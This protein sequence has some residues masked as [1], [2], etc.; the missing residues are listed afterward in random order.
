MSQPIIGTTSY[1]RRLPSGTSKTGRRQYRS[2][3]Q[4]RKG[5]RACDIIL[6]EGP[7]TPQSAA[8]CSNCAKTRKPCTLVWLNSSH[9]AVAK[10]KERRGSSQYQQQM[11]EQHM[12][13]ET[14]WEDALTNLDDKLYPEPGD[15][16]NASFE[17]P[18]SCPFDQ[19]FLG[20]PGQKFCSTDSTSAESLLDT[21]FIYGY[22][23]GS[24]E[25]GF[26]NRGNICSPLAKTDSGYD[27]SI[28]SPNL[29]TPAN[30][31]NPPVHKKFTSPRE[32]SPKRRRS[33]SSSSPKPDTDRTNG[34][35]N[36]LL[37]QTSSHH[38][39]L[40]SPSPI[41]LEHRIALSYSKA[42]ISSGLVRIY[43]DSRSPL[44]FLRLSTYIGRIS[45]V[46][47]DHHR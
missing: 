20:I 25:T 42:S 40:R 23:T 34:R 9:Q 41:S 11:A 15:T 37:C 8:P 4:C 39:S 43:H 16:T 1:R 24:I 22:E 2:C 38:R 14:S 36:L 18:L 28:F 3:D 17:L 30:T 32:R 33:G 13:R 29:T 31:F 46:E 10:G 7:V 47:F 44:P 27:S 35:R 6:S 12:G 45:C 5:K 26:S 21:R 19:T